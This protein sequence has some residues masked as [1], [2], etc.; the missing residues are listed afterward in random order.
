MTISI[1]KKMGWE[2]NKTQ[3]SKLKAITREENQKREEKGLGSNKNLT[4]KIVQYST[5][6]GRKWAGEKKTQLSKLKAITR[7]E[8]KK[9][10]KMGWEEN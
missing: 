7:E 3:L 4:L 10:K 1:G 2:K 6:Q 9:R 5:V 8:N